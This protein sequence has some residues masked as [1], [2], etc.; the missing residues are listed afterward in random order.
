MI[1]S[2]LREGGWTTV[3]VL[4]ALGLHVATWLTL[5]VAV[6]KARVHNAGMAAWAAVVLSAALV[7]AVA[8]SYFT[9]VLGV[10]IL[11]VVFP[12][13]LPLLISPRPHAGPMR[14]R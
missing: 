7:P 8:L 6:W 12:I 14:P 10:P 9:P 11:V 3:T 2:L 1:W 5:G 4:A 13:R